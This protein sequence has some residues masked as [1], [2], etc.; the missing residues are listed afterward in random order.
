[1][2]EG[3]AALDY[4]PGGF[5]EWRCVGVGARGTGGG[6]RT[7]LPAAQLHPRRNAGIS[8]LQKCRG[9]TLPAPGITIRKQGRSLER[10]GKLKAGPK[11]PWEDQQCGH[12]GSIERRGTH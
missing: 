10:G 3:G 5:K 4:Y 11:S 1:M 7:I 9:I 8:I 6:H 12:E 2:V